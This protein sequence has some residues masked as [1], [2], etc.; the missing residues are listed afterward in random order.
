M[1]EIPILGMQR[2]NP[3]SKTPDGCCQEIVGLRY[4]SGA[5]RPVGSKKKIDSGMSAY[6]AFFVHVMDTT[7]NLI[8]RWNS[9]IRWRTMYGYPTQQA[10]SVVITTVD[11]GD[12]VRFEA[13]GNVLI[14]LNEAKKTLSWAFFDKDSTVT[15][16]G[17]TV[18][19][20]RYRHIE[21]LPELPV[22]DFWADDDYMETSNEPAYKGPFPSSETERMEF[23]R[24]QADAYMAKLRKKMASKGYFDGY[25]FLTYAY[26]L[27]DG[28]VVKHANPMSLYGGNIEMLRTELPRP[29]EDERLAL[30]FG[31][32]KIECRGLQFRKL[33]CVLKQSVDLSA[34]KDI[35]RG[36]NVYISPI[37]SITFSDNVPNEV[38]SA[39][40]SFPVYY[41]EGDLPSASFEGRNDFYLLKRIDTSEL[42]TYLAGK[43]LEE[44]ISNISSKAAMPTDNNSHHTL[45]GDASFTYNS[46]LFLGD[47]TAK[48]FGGWPLKYYNEA[49]SG[50]RLYTRVE[51]QT[52]EGLKTVDSEPFQIGD[53]LN[54]PLIVSYPD[55]R[56][57]KLELLVADT[58]VNV[59]DTLVEYGAYQ[60]DPVLSLQLKPHPFLNLSYAINPVVTKG[61]HTVPAEFNP[62]SKSV[63]SHFTNSQRA[64]AEAGEGTIDFNSDLLSDANRSQISELSNPFYFPAKNSDQVGDRRILGYAANA[65]PLSQGQF[66]QHPVLVFTESGMWAMQLGVDPFIQAITPLNGEVLVDKKNILSIG[67]ATVFKTSEGLKLI[68]GSSITNLSDSVK[69]LDNALLASVG[70]GIQHITESGVL[71]VTDHLVSKVPFLDYLKDA[72]L[73]YD[74]INRELLVANAAYGYTYVLSFKHSYWF[75]LSLA[76]TK[77]ISCYPDF[78]FVGKDGMV[79]QL[80]AEHEESKQAFLQT[81]P[82]DMEKHGFKKLRRTILRGVLRTRGSSSKEFGFYLFA[83]V[84]GKKWQALTGTEV[85]GTVRDITLQRQLPSARF[86]AVVASGVLQPD[87]FITAISVDD[88][89]RLTRRMR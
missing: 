47:I 60:G 80:N 22:F 68:E 38:R 66:G 82:V 72:F 40:V 28:S 5:W 48:L 88:E 46:R 51:L 69:L 42:D 36:I 61:I 49:G 31:D 81:R 37:T 6:T 75:K 12:T 35:I 30:F 41:K 16:G 23:I 59:N 45:Y 11:A 86:I 1:K 74:T 87:S 29:P 7:H 24:N 79:Y 53:Q 25:L 54:L 85:G 3:D 84:D 83:S 18:S 50:S 58:P 8:Y 52:G 34:Y 71:G 65:I 9:E 20:Y 32:N 4:D 78:F 56:A 17:V 55:A 67:G 2:N 13:I 57:K 14:I 44:D 39:P 33:K 70:S 21:Q 10:A 26:E 43:T 62:L 77:A 19:F 64:Y 73:G 89:D 63:G 76:A 27:F 15:D